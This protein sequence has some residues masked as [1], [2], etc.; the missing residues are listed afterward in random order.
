MA[1]RKLKKSLSLGNSLF[2]E[3]KVVVPV[4]L[5]A[6]VVGVIFMQASSASSYVFVNYTNKM[7]HTMNPKGKTP[8]ANRKISNVTYKMHP[9]NNAKPI[10]LVST[11]QAKKSQ[12]LCAHFKIVQLGRPTSATGHHIAIK[13]RMPSTSSTPGNAMSISKRQ[14]QTGWICLD[15]RNIKAGGVLEISTDAFRPTVIGVD[16]FYGKPDWGSLKAW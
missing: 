13:Y 8:P 16:T 9:D 1:K 15:A 12:R 10:T 11:E 6:A 7:G 3:K 14:G 2:N 4:L 5:I